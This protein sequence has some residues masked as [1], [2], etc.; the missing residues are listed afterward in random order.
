MAVV[1][2]QI[3][4]PQAFSI[5]SAKLMLAIKPMKTPILS[6]VYL[7]IGSLSLIAGV[8]NVGI[9]LFGQGGASESA[10][11]GAIAAFAGIVC[12]GIAEVVTLIAKIEH[13]TS[14]D[15]KSG[16]QIEQL[17][18][19]TLST[20]K[21]LLRATKSAIDLPPVPGQEKYYVSYD[22]AIDGPYRIKDIKDLYDKGALSY[23]SFYIEERGK[24]WKTVSEIN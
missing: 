14:R 4:S 3:E 24:T 2:F 10:I 11:T 23:D 8:A 18:K 19:E 15:P 13:N 7:L 1:Q 20:L 21:S 22:G 9:A 6:S 5:G 17:H 12:I 16:S